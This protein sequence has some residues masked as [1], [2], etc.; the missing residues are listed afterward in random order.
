MIRRMQRWGVSKSQYPV[1]WRQRREVVPRCTGLLRI[2][3][4]EREPHFGKNNI[5]NCI[6]IIYRKALPE[7]P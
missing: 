2:S 4:D 6:I 5:Q 1:S 7:I 3:H